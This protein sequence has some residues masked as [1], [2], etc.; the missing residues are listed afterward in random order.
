MMGLDATSPRLKARIAGLSQ[1]LEAVCATFGQIV[2]LGKLVV[3]G[4]AAVTAMNILAHQRLYWLGFAISLLGVAF[5]AIWIILF[6][7]LFR[8]V[9]KTVALLAVFIGTVECAMQALTGFL[10]LSPLIILNTVSTP[11]GL[12][13]QQLQSLAFVF[14]KLNAYA[15]DVHIMFFGLWCVLTGYL[16]FKSTF[17]PRTLGVLLTISGLGWLMYLDPPFAVQIFPVIAV[18]SAIG[19]IPLEFWLMIK[20]VNVPR[21]QEVASASRVRLI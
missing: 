15:F 18:A 16:I 2:V 20:S 21:W 9:N 10:Y 8:P 17:L 11:N 13:M 5:H 12:T 4:D 1:L 3:L 7:D 6:Y 14:L 19:E